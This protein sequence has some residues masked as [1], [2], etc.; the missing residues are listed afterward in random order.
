[1]KFFA[2][3]LLALAGFA[4]ASPALAQS[5][6]SGDFTATAAC[7]A[8][9]SIHKL[10]NPGNV[11][12]AVG[13][14]YNIEGG[15]TANPTYF[16]IVVP[17]A[18]PDHRWVPIT[19]GT[20]TVAITTSPPPDTGPGPKP[21]PS[22]KTQ[23]VFAVSWEPAFCEGNGMADK[24]E[25]KGQTANSFEATHLAL[26]GLWPQP[27]SN[28]YCNVSAADK[29]LDDAH[30][31]DQLPAVNLSPATRTAL[32]QTMPGTQSGLERHEWITHGTCYGGTQEQYFSDAIT[33]IGAINAS[34]VRDLFAGNVGKTL[35]LGQIRTAFD[36]AFGTGAGERVRVACSRDGN[37]SL[38]EE[39]TIGLT[40]TITDRA[41]VGALILTASP[42][43]GGCPSGLVDPVGLQ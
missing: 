24:A 26:H 23:Y 36:Q 5:K 18:K 16:W 20:S 40:G 34:P 43:S 1:M 38:I 19:C 42:T 39:V 8:V 6:M 2:A 14:K 10:T 31:W 15:N 32:G 37:R 28:S 35:T 13:T 11:T 29:A 9:T 33:V 30:H 41:G 21:S 27:R 22:G 17:A 3:L 7:P 25:C 4:L 12:L